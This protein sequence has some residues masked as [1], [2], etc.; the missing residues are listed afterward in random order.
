MSDTDFSRVDPLWA[1]GNFVFMT[2]VNEDSCLQAMRFISW[3][4]MRQSSMEENKQPP[5]E[6]LTIV[7]NSPG[8]SLTACFALIDTM[9]TSSIPVNTLVLGQVCSC[10]FIIAMAGANRAMSENATAMSHT[11]SWGTSGKH[12]DLVHARKSQ[13]MTDNLIRRHYKK[14]TKKSD[15]YIR[16]NLLP[17]L[18]DIWLTP[19][20][21]LEHGVID[22]IKVIP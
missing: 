4:N 7:I 22:E 3:H 17:D 10:G 21:C 18:G 5:L 8:G 19:E 9:R 14:C 20:E 16:K 11:Y 6:N 1:S 2:G 13:D 15:Q 12:G